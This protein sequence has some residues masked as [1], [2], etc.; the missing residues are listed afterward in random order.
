MDIKNLLIGIAIT[1]LSFLV[2][3]TG[4][5]T[6]YP[7]PEYDDFCSQTKPPLVP[8]NQTLC[9]QD[10]KEC[11]DGSY[12][13]RDP[14]NDCEF[15]PCESEQEKCYEQYKNARTKHSKNIFI[16]TIILS[17]ILLTIGATFFKLNNVSSGIMGGGIITLLYG[18][19]SYWPNA[20]NLARFI[21][22]LIGLSILIGFTYWMNKKK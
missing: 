16:I 3:F 4:I 2:I 9:A 10:V 21:I 20:E 7:S 15:F 14:N 12:V 13:S 11:P 1:I 22:S 18:A 6:F 5:Q 17:L 8:K 19:F